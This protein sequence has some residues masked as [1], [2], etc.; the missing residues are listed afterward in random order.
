MAVKSSIPSLARE[1]AII[2]D[3]RLEARLVVAD[4][5]HLVDREHE[6]PDAEQ[7]GE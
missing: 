5:V 6:V 3:D 7:C 2:G 4:Q 1:G